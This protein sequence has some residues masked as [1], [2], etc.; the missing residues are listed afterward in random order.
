MAGSC[1][2]KD[3][4]ALEYLARQRGYE[5]RTVKAAIE[6]NRIRKILSV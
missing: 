1:F 6:V 4:K 3:T 2:P 5:L